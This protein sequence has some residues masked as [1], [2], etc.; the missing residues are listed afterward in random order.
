M[1]KEKKFLI[2]GIGLVLV[3]F[4]G[5]TL[6][7]FMT[8]IQ[9]DKKDVT[10]NTGD[11]RVIFNNG[12]EIVGS[13]VEPGWTVTKTF[14]IE[15]KS[16][17]EY[18]YNIVIQDLVNTFVSNNMVYKITSTNS[19]LNMTDYDV[20]PK[21]DTA[22]NKVLSYN[23]S[24][25]GKTTQEYTIEVKFQEE[26]RNQYEDMGKVLSGNLY[27]EEGTQKPTTF[28]SAILRDNP[29]VSERTDFSVINVANTTGTIYKTNKTEDG[30]DIYYYSGNTTNNWVK[31]GGL[32]WRIIRTNEDGGVRLLYVGTNHDSGSGSIAGSDFNKTSYDPID[33]GYMYGTSGSLE[34]N[35]TNTNDSSIKT[36]VDTWYKNNLLTNYDKYISKTAIYCNDRSVGK[37]TYNVGKAGSTTFYFGAYAR[38][39]LNKAPSYKCGTDASGT[40]FSTAN[41][42]DKFS[43]NTSSGGNGQLKYPI[44]LMTADEVVFAGGVINTN[45]S[46]PYAWYYTDSKGNAITTL[47][48]WLL[49]P[50][51]CGSSSNMF[52]VI[53]SGKLS[54]SVVGSYK[55]NDSAYRDVVRPVLSLNSCVIVTGTGTATDPYVVDENAS[56]C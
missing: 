35:R 15:N 43:A 54:N 45:L 34:S 55:S 25:A 32:Y 12:D 52:N 6:A 24:I 18:K 42:A 19:G 46:N 1:T 28:A 5:V 27:I 47:S 30:S 38:L 39:S 8:M 29:I 51:N 14:S 20:L 37:G 48:W 16:K 44:A 41:T 50:Y 33:I 31:F 21:S 2:Y 40:L 9:G 23:N 13:K 26:D 3:T 36:V 22:S 49:T 11:L 17:T 10:I 7:Y 53:A 4:I 56:T